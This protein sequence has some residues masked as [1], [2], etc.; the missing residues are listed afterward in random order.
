MKRQT[1]TTATKT[2]TPATKTAKPR[3]ATNARGLEEGQLWQLTSGFMRIGH[4]GKLLVQYKLMKV[5][6]RRAVP[7]R[8]SSIQ[9]VRNLL[10]EHRAV[11]VKV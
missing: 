5:P 3:T 6:E 10:K 4:V 1:T 2:T 8:I 11:L 7:V 9:D